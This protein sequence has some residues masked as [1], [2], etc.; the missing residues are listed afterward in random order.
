MKTIMF[1]AFPGSLLIGLACLIPLHPAFSA[2]PEPA[3]AAVTGANAQPGPAIVTAP[4]EAKLPYGIE[5]VVKLSRAQIS[6][7][8]V[9]NYIRN[10]GTIYTLGPQ[11]IVYLRNQ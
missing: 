6:D 10:S 5:D 1:K 8:V 9:I 11:E 2:D 3:P 7:D 4:P